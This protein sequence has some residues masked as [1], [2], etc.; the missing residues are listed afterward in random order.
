MLIIDFVCFEVQIAEMYLGLSH[1]IFK[2]KIEV[3]IDQ[4]FACMTNSTAAKRTS[5][6]SISHRVRFSIKQV[7]PQELYLLYDIVRIFS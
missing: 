2:N 6:V 5:A 7:Y 4:M 1:F 3:D